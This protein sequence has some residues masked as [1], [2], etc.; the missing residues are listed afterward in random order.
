MSEKS[1]ENVIDLSQNN[2][3][4]FD[5]TLGSLLNYFEPDKQFPSGY[6]TLEMYTKRLKDP[7]YGNV[8]FRS[9]KSFNFSNSFA[10]K[11]IGTI[12]NTPKLLADCSVSIS[13]TVQNV[14]KNCPLFVPNK[15]HNLDTAKWFI[16]IYEKAKYICFCKT[17]AID[18]D[19]NRLFEALYLKNEKD[20]AD[21]LAII[22]EYHT[23]VKNGN[24]NAIKYAVESLKTNWFGALLPRYIDIVTETAHKI[25]WTPISFEMLPVYM[26]YFGTIPVSD[27]LFYPYYS[28]IRSYFSREVPNMCLSMGPP[29]KVLKAPPF[30][31]KVIVDVGVFLKYKA[32]LFGGKI[33]FYRNEQ[34]Y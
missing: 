17:V 33:S 28:Q 12:A 15:A 31:G 26:T 34:E 30:P 24:N 29:M 7:H 18:I 25:Y 23:A 2:S 5:Y 21:K 19:D 13:E 9:L 32:P 10:N 11:L 3:Q 22:A 16:I 4:Y 1:V 14:I 20:R 6:E 8:D 27:W